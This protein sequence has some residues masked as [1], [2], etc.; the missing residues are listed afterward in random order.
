MWVLR[1][2]SVEVWFFHMWVLRNLTQLIRLGGGHSYHGTTT[3]GLKW[4]ESNKYSRWQGVGTALVALTSTLVPLLS[5]APGDSCQEEVTVKAT[6]SYVPVP[7]IMFTVHSWG[8]SGLSVRAPPQASPY[9]QKSVLIT[10]PIT[11]SPLAFV[12]IIFNFISMCFHLFFSNF[13]YLILR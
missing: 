7:I 10:A 6:W 4:K 13:I 5:A 9:Y 3:P 2:Q 1:R 11:C 12:C 8:R